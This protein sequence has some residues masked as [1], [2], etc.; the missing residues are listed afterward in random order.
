M[1][2]AFGGNELV[3]GTGVW[4][5]AQALTLPISFFCMREKGVERREGEDMMKKK[6][7]ERNGTEYL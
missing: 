2:G 7:L 5:V 6:N 4:K 3:V 1:N